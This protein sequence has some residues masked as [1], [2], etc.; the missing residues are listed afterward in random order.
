MKIK[1]ILIDVSSHFISEVEF[2]SEL[3]SYYELLKCECITTA[4]YDD[5]HD[6]IVDD[7]GLL[8]SSSGFF[9]MGEAEFAGNGLIVGFDK[10]GRWISHKLNIDK[11]RKSV[12][13]ID[14]V[15]FMGNTFK[16]IF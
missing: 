1:G 10:R 13:F 12:Q 16:I 5:F 6:L 2:E 14:Y 4:L 11:I 3:S 15:R 9:K 8:K 7:E